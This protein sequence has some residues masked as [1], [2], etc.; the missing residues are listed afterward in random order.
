[1]FSFKLI[2]QSSKSKARVGRLIT[3]NGIID[4]PAFIFCATKADVKGVTIDQVRNAGTQII[5]SNAYHLMLQPGSSIIKKSGGL[6]KF[7]GWNG[8]MLTDS[9]GFQIF[10]LGHGG[11]A[12]EI[13]GI[14]R[15]NGFKNKKTMLKISEEGALFR[16]YIDGKKILITPEISMKIQQDLG[17]DLIVSFDECTP[18][19]VD[20]K[21]TKES[22]ERSKRWGLRSLN[23]INETGDG[24]QKILAVIQGGVYKDLREESADFANNHNFF[25]FAI[26]GSLGKTEQ[27]MRDIVEMTNS[28]LDKSRSVHLL[29]IGGIEDIFYGVM[30]GID[31]FDC[32][33]PTRIARH[34]MAIVKKKFCNGKN[35]TDLSNSIYKEDCSPISED[36]N[37]YTCQSFSRSYINHLFK[38]K[39]SLGGSLISIHNIYTMNRLMTDIRNGIINDDGNTNNAMNSVY[40][41]W[42]V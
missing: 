18:F 32:V 14:A 27:E 5:L 17:A 29:G 6:G 39:E 22:M 1:M 12:S 9:G 15:C 28:M 40:K 38:G 37:C 7:T 26:G 23:Y 10:S 42:C 19:H 2:K 3:P 41:D 35:Y 33:S 11:V 13:K 20:K 16:S 31:T 34:G 30:Y 21:Y 24:T 36:C 4:T 8:P 25:G